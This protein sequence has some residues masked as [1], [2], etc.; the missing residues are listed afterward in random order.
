M[1]RDPSSR[2]SMRWTTIGVPHGWRS[3]TVLAV[4]AMAGLAW[5]GW[6]V[7]SSATS[8][9][10]AQAQGEAP[11][12]MAAL[13]CGLVA[14]GVAMWLDA[15][16]RLDALAPLTSLVVLNT[17]VRAVV[18]PAANGVELVHALPLLAGMSAGAP[19]GFLV[20]AASALVSTIA[21]GDPASTLPSQ[22][23][24][25]GL[26]GM[27]GGLL[28]RVRA[29]SAWLASVPLALAAGV[30]SGVLLNLI[31]WG[32]E[33]GTTLT[34]FYRGLSPI[35]VASRLWGFTVETSLVLDLTRGAT[36]AGLLLVTGYPLLVSLR[37]GVGTDTPPVPPPEHDPISAQ[38]L[39]RRTD[40]TRF[41]D[42]WNR[43][44]TPWP[45]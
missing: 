2:A 22:A 9:G 45:T 39:G 42:L 10:R 4:L 29:R 15:G 18:N 5:L 28:W 1:T 41:E 44:D 20:G 37:R 34:S 12:V 43:G 27:L 26:S 31:G 35:E 19:A 21:V 36:T 40:R 14:L 17:L 8:P 23:L 33:P 25:W 11:W 32:Q 7:W 38:T 6:P 30:L 16:R 24:V 13:V 3:L